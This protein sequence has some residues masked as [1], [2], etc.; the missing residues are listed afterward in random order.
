MTKRI[1]HLTTVPALLLFFAVLYQSESQALGERKA[2]DGEP[3]TV[4]Q[5]IRKIAKKTGWTLPASPETL[6]TLKTGTIRLGSS[7]VLKRQLQ[8][9][10]EPL[11]TLDRF[12]VE[13]GVLTLS[14]Q[15][16]VVREVYALEV[17]GK[18][19][20]YEAVFVEVALLD[21]G[22]RQYVGRAYRIFYYDEDG[23]GLF[24]ARYTLQP[25]TVPD[26]AKDK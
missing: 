1:F 10:S 13:D 16:C 2:K 20:A 5:N 8:L 23:D 17:A 22:V 3:Q 7:M 18:T 11:F 12:I 14:S 19:F 4:G 15:L 24:E 26:W 21:G 25:Q 6:G 9:H